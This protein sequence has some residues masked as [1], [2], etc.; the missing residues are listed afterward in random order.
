MYRCPYN[1][2]TLVTY[3]NVRS[4]AEEIMKNNSIPIDQ[5]IP[6]FEKF[7]ATEYKKKK[8]P[9]NN[10][11]IDEGQDLSDNLL[12]QLQVFAEERNGT[13]YIFYDRNQYIFGQGR[14]NCFEYKFYTSCKA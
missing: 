9:Y 14:S 2:H 12:G 4:L 8:W 6:A 1:T 3:H 11:I 5:V 10:I 7:L 13:F